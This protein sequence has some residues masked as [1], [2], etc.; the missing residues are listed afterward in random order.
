MQLQG[1][2]VLVTGASRGIGSAIATACARAGAHVGIGYRSNADAARRTRDAITDLGGSAT[3]HCFDVRDRAAVDAAVAAFAAE[4]GTLDVLVNNAGVAGDAF[5]FTMSVD[6]WNHVVEVDLTG[7]FHC[8]R[9]AAATMMRAR[10]GCIINIASVAGIR[11]S[12]GQVN[13]SAAKGGLLAVTRTLAAELGRFGVRVN[14]VVPGMIATGMVERMDQRIVAR[15]T[16]QIPL[17]RLGRAEEVA[18]VVTFMASDAAAYIT[19]QAIVVDGGWA[20]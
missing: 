15:R 6:A 14:A 12:P 17:G 7:P 2:T 19:G 4:H 1:R 8:A 18:S 3:L 5:A 16:E 9:A 13:Y 10:R 20:M 11:A